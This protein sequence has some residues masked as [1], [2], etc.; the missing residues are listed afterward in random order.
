M[1]YQ[2]TINQ[3]VLS[4]TKLD[5]IDGAI[6]DFLIFFH[7]SK[8]KKIDQKRKEGWTWVNYGELMK[9]MPMLGIKSR[10]AI[11][12]RIR[13]LEEEKFI[14]TK[15][16][17]RK[18]YFKTLPRTDRL[19][20]SMNSIVH[21]DE[22]YRSSRR[23]NKVYKDKDNKDKD[24]DSSKK[25]EKFWSKYPKKE[26]KA[27]AKRIWKRKNIGD[28]LEEILEFIKNAK[29]T[30]RWNEGYIPMPTTFLN[31]KRWQDDLSSYGKIKKKPYYR[32]DPVVDKGG[33]K[34]VIS[35]GEWLEFA[36]DK[37]DIEWK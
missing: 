33:K 21:E 5:L 28:N 24:R 10:G 17:G 14:V 29:K 15:K 31:Q 13:K 32:G 2:I 25:F 34:Y 6:L 1:K 36:G 16:I 35:N 12:P 27:K 9:Q 37:D 18:I 23:T 7:N 26:A 11:T 19:F 22:R 8:S 30:E 20:I 3:A 4:K